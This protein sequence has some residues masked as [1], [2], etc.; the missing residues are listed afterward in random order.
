MLTCS[1]VNMKKLLLSL[2]LYLTICCV[3]YL[4]M[5]QPSKQPP[6]MKSILIWNSIGRIE[7]GYFNVGSSSFKECPVSQC[8]I[9]TEHT[10][11]PFHQF[12]AVVMN[13]FDVHGS[14]LPEVEGF[15]RSSHQRYVFLQLESP[16]V[17]PLDVSLYLNYFNWTMTYKLNSFFCAMKLKIYF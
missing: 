15:N 11:L 17:S 16:K 3:Y 9:F 14:P 8:R 5:M 7:T 10:D 12:D 1:E 4:L 13:M 2:S 6:P